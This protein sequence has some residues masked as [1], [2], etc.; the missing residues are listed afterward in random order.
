MLILQSISLLNTGT[1]ESGVA[2]NSYGRGQLVGVTYTV[3]A[4]AEISIDFTAKLQCV[5][6]DNVRQMDALIRSLLDASKYEK[7]DELTKTRAGGGFSF[8]GFF[9]GGASASYEQTRHRMS[10][11]GLSEANQKAIVDAMMELAEQFNVFKFSGTVYN[12]ENDYSVSGSMF[13]LVMD[14]TITQGETSKQVRTIGEKPIFVGDDGSAL[15]IV[16][17]LKP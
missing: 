14:C 13:A 1:A 10:G 11:W 7:F 3:P 5:T 9:S 12:K 8:F 2:I 15:P 17:L 4:H 16:G 6:M